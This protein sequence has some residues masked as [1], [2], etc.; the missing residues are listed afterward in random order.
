MADEEKIPSGLYYVIPAQIFEDDRLEHSETV[1]YAL[2]SG[3]SFSSGYCFASDAYLAKRMKVDDSTIQRWMKKLEDLRYLRRETSKNGM[4]WERKIFITHSRLDSKDSYEASSKR[5]SNPYPKGDR[6]RAHKDIA[7]KETLDSEVMSH[8]HGFSKEEIRKCPELKNQGSLQD[9]IT[10]L[11]QV[12]FP[13]GTTVSQRNLESWCR[14]YS[15]WR[16][17]KASSRIRRMVEAGK[18]LTNP[19]GLF[20]AILKDPDME[21]TKEIEEAREA[22]YAFLDESRKPWRVD[23]GFVIDDATQKDVPLSFGTER[24]I[25]ELQRWIDV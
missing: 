12:I 4:K 7:C 5:G 1:F 20:Y 8:E 22:V 11:K 18:P 2:L 6:S 23:D 24:V 14:M 13:D 17:K 16:M 25:E 21:S 10:F 19:E 3:L 15:L 9:K